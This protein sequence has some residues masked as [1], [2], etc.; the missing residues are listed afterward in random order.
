[1][2]KLREEIT[3][4]NKTLTKASDAMELTP[5]EIQI[6]KNA[7]WENK[8]IQIGSEP[9]Y[10]Y[11]NV[12][13]KD[14]PS[15]KTYKYCDSSCIATQDANAFVAGLT[16]GLSALLGQ[17]PDRSRCIRW[18]RVKQADTYSTEVKKTLVRYEPIMEEIV[19]RLMIIYKCM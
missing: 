15:Y 17:G 14:P 9:I 2:V 4:R 1:M 3:R 10:K 6:L 7:D 13:V 5:T 12:S 16:L 19:S 8:T 11:E 18:K